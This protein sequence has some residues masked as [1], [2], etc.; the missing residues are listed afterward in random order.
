MPTLLP[1]SKRTTAATATFACIFIASPMQGAGQFTTNP[2]LLD[3]IQL[4]YAQLLNTY[5]LLIHQDTANNQSDLYAAI[6]QAETAVAA[7]N[8]T[9]DAIMAETADTKIVL[10]GMQSVVAQALITLKNVIADE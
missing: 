10:A 3:A 1:F 8:V 9:V 5:P 6:Q 7:L 4:E 2:T